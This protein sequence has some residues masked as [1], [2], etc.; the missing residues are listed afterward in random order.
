MEKR[1]QE[2]GSGVCLAKPPPRAFELLV[3]VAASSILLDEV[4]VLA[5]LKRAVE[6]DD[7]GMVELAVD[8][9]FAFDLW[10][11]GDGR[12]TLCSTPT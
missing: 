6:L 4:D 3:Q 2:A 9:D 1:L 12:G 5:V 10:Y 7:V 11:C 8:A